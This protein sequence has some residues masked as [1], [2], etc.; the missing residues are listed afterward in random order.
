MGSPRPAR[1]PK[2]PRRAALRMIVTDIAPRVAALPV[3][4]AAAKGGARAAAQHQSDT[5]AEAI[6]HHLRRTHG[7]RAALGGAR[8]RISVAGVD[9]QTT[10]GTA[11]LL[12]LWIA[13]ARARL[14]RGMQ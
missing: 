8:Q 4:S 10:M 5:Q 14:E 1:R 13:T 11:N 3:V 2:D 12:R 6:I 7:A 9:V